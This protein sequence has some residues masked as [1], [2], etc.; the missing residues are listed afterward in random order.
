[1]SKFIRL[2]KSN[3]IPLTGDIFIL[4][5]H[6]FS[7]DLDIKDVTGDN[8]TPAEDGK[9]N[10]KWFIEEGHTTGDPDSTAL[11]GVGGRKPLKYPRQMYIVNDTSGSVDSDFVN[12]LATGD[13]IHLISN[14]DENIEGV[15]TV[16]TT[17]CIS[18]DANTVKINSKDYLD[19]DKNWSL[20][21]ERDF[22]KSF[23]DYDTKASSTLDNHAL[24]AYVEK[25]DNLYDPINV[26]TDDI[27]SYEKHPTYDSEMFVTFKEGV[28][29][30]GGHVV[31]KDII[32]TGA[33]NDIVIDA[34]GYTGNE[35]KIKIEIDSTTN[36]ET[37]KWRFEDYIE[38]TN[39]SS[40]YAETQRGLS[41]QFTPLNL[42]DGEIKVKWLATTG[43]TTDTWTFTV[44]PNSKRIYK[45]KIKELDKLY[46]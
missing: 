33:L 17:D 46:R 40:A 21:R 22:Q 37:F 6:F 4:L 10:K 41:L 38:W 2:H 31:L 35:V 16:L 7:E 36:P 32:H 29:S 45:N 12:E 43:H 28:F 24:K 39:P 1:M 11:E 20:F 15:F 25:R 14:N 18:C 27:F 26:N 5:P 13:V 30:K 9:D 3:F 42:G 19:Q 8:F 44:Y 23:F 34:S